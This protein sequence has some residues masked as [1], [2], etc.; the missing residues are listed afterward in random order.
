M[1]F[2][3]AVWAFSPWFNKISLS[4]LR[5]PTAIHWGLLWVNGISSI[6]VAGGLFGPKQ[7]S[8]NRIIIYQQPIFRAL[9][10]MESA[11]W[12]D[13]SCHRFALNAKIPP[14]RAKLMPLKHKTASN[15][16]HIWHNLLVSWKLY[17]S[18]IPKELMV[19][20][21][22]KQS[23]RQSITSAAVA[24]VSSALCSHLALIGQINA[25]FLTFPSGSVYRWWC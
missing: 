12:T 22:E 25:C 18:N 21:F 19:A 23:R 11:H 13:W 14:H 1:T 2:K 6:V 24:C 9:N 5:T 7:D 20:A 15:C 17:W 16:M 10:L 8:L 4:S 3:R